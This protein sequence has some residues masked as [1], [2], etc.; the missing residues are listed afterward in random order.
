M[1]L[2]KTLNPARVDFIIRQNYAVLPVS[3]DELNQELARAEKLCFSKNTNEDAPELTFFNPVT[4]CLHGLPKT[5]TSNSNQN[6]T[7][8][9][10]NTWV[11]DHHNFNEKHVVLLVDPSYKSIDLCFEDNIK[12]LSKLRKTGAHVTVLQLGMKPT[13]ILAI[14]MSWVEDYID[15][16][17]RLLRADKEQDVYADRVLNS[18]TPIMEA[19]AHAM[20]TQ[21]HHN[22]YYNSLRMLFG[23]LTKDIRSVIKGF[24]ETPEEK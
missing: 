14:D 7:I 12:L 9:S 5:E 18:Y 19:Y 23:V 22:A 15:L 24:P 2:T 1:L 8:T 11:I 16:R 17:S 21:I 20:Q 6:V 10:V 4:D 13:Y 3:D